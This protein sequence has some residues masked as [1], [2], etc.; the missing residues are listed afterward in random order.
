VIAV[1]CLCW[2]FFFLKYTLCGPTHSI[3]PDIIAKS[4]LIEDILFWVGY[5]NSML[6]P[7]L[8]NFTNQDFRKAFRK[9]LHLNKRK[10]EKP[11]FVSK[12]CVCFKTQSP[13]PSRSLSMVSQHSR[14]QTTTEEIAL[15]N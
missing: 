12:Y 15:V 2:F 14:K 11:S 8:Y 13:N 10:K 3:C 4:V 7:F 1:F 9:L 6:N 5:F